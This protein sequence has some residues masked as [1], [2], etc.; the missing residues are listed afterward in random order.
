MKRGRAEIDPENKKQQY[1]ALL[2][3]KV[4]DLIGRRECKKIS[5]EAVLKVYEKETKK[6]K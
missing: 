2:P 1:G 3:K 4:V 6:K 5:E